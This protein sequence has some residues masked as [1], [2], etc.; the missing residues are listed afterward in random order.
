MADALHCLHTFKDVFLLRQTGQNGQAKPNALRTQL[1]NKRN[2][3]EATNTEPWTPSMKLREMN[4][5][6]DYVSHEIDV[7][8]E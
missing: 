3:D 2:V 4:S 5:W 6:L 7:L 1:V 8:K